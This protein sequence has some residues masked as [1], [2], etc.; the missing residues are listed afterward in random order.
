MKKLKVLIYSV[1]ATVCSVLIFFAVFKIISSN[2]N[3]ENEIIVS[4][5]DA[6]LEEVTPAIES[7]GTIQYKTKT[8][9]ISL[10]DGMTIEKKVKE[11]DFVKKGQIVYVLKNTELEIQHSQFIN[12]L[13]SSKA[14]LELYQAKLDE[15]KQF[16]KSELIN[17]ENKKL[18]IEQ[19]ERQLILQNDLLLKNKE[20]HKLGGVTDFSITEL[21]NQ[22]SSL[23]TNKEILLHQLAISQLGYTEEALIQN[24]ITPSS[25]NTEFQKQLIS[26]NTKTSQADLE[27]AKAN[28]ENAK[29]NLELIEHL[30]SDLQIRSPIDG[31]VGATYFEPGEYISKNEKIITIMDVSTCIASITLQESQMTSVYPGMNADIEVP[32]LNKT[33][34]TSITEISPFA[35]PSTGTFYVKAYFDNPDSII[36][37]GMF[38]K[39]EIKMEKPESFLTIPESA[40]LNTTDNQAE[41]FC[42]KNGIAV[43]HLIKIKSIKDGTVYIYEGIKS[44]DKIINFPTRKIKE[45][46]HVKIS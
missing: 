5:L 38:I 28:Y 22:I 20:L 39:C 13:T 7:Y 24:G 45:G 40:I 11:G 17:I 14:N 41:C 25:D 42:V 19:I 10:Q 12:E 33:L 6:K 8:D 26:L 27:V 18:E 9:V 15:K 43:K 16:A 3:T 35:D 32:A 36:K 21:E 37:P 44:D 34:T 2:K 4:T 1:S 23:N 30:I 31:I 46:S 29:K